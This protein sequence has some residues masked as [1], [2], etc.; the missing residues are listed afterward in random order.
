MTARDEKDI[1]VYNV[2]TLTHGRVLVREARAAAQR[3]VLVGFHGYME[4]A[5]IQMERLEAIPG[6]SAWTLVSIQG[7][8]RFYRGRTDQVVAS[9]MTRED[10]EDAIADN[11][12][13]VSA[14]MEQV[15]HDHST[16]VVYTGF[17]QGV[18]MAFRAGLL[19][20]ARAVAIAAVGGDVPPEL[21]TDPDVRFPAILLTR[22]ARDEWLTE[23][24]F[25]RDVAAM[26]ARGVELTTK[27]YDGGHEWNDEVCRAIGDFL[28]AL[29]SRES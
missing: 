7:L 8:H 9:W 18:A 17:S 1:S 11:L 4:T 29:P 6:S 12:A 10:R 5:Q 19:G 21:L 26:N 24:R 13:Y 27:V 3:G 14:A 23:P 15:P 22:G 28:D 20:V 2:P 16:P 25:E